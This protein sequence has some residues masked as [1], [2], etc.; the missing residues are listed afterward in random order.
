VPTSKGD[1]YVIS[2]STALALTIP[3]SA[4]LAT[5]VDTSSTDQQVVVVEGTATCADLGLGDRGTRINQPVTSTYPLDALNTATLMFDATGT[6]FNVSS[7]LRF[8]GIL[9][10]AGD[11]AAVWPIAPE[12]NGWPSLHGPRGVDGEPLPI[13]AVTI[14]Y[15]YDLLVNPNAY[16]H[17]RRR[18]TW[19]VAKVGSTAQLTLAAGQSATVEYDVTVAATG[20]ADDGWVIEGPVFAHNSTPISATIHSVAVDVGGITATVICPVALPYALAG[21]RSLECS[22]QAS[23][24]DGSDRLV[25][26]HVEVDGLSA[27]DGAEL[28]S[29]SSHTTKTEI[30]DECVDATDSRVG[31]LG[32]VCAGD[33][34]RTFHYSLAIGP[35]ETCGPYTYDNTATIIGHDSG[36]TDSSTWTVDVDVEC[37]EGRVCTLTPGY[38]QTHSELGPAPYDAT[39][40]QLPNG[41]ST[42]FFGSGQTYLAVLRAAPRG[43]AYYILGQAY[44]A[45]ALNRLAGTDFTAAQSAFDTA[46]ALF[47]TTTPAQA[48]ALGTS[49]R[50]T[51]INAAATLDAYNNGRLGPLHCD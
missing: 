30:V 17:V 35:Y 49:A 10:H 34:P 1:T 27:P 36:A 38:W 45:A 40:A 11:D 21:G 28:A 12:N 8:D 41:A 19:D 4:C 39:W 20:T 29:F 25:V 15:D 47:Q 37:N 51:W 33:A 2:T 46:T 32:T 24:P 50:A 42:A 9:V 3:L 7:S 44:I 31:A 5:D 6:S 16:A 14:C 18:R 48:A 22:Y 23:L 26:V 13:D 43:N